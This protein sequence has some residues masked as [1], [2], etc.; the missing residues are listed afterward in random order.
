M[1]LSL[2]TIVF[3]TIFTPCDA[4]WRPLT[5]CVIEGPESIDL[6]GMNLRF[7]PDS[8]FKIKNLE[9]LYLDFNPD[10]EVNKLFEDLK[11]FENLTYLSLKGCKLGVIPESIKHLKLLYYC[12]N[13]G[14][15]P[16]SK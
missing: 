2:L 9:G 16:K 11:V 15:Q 5:D 14:I 12:K 6:S 4:Q 13:L 10:L 3:L 8:L 7:L 1:R